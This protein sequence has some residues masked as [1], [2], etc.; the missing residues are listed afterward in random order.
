M[1]LTEGTWTRYGEEGVGM[2]MEGRRGIGR[3]WKNKVKMRVLEESLED[4]RKMEERERGGNGVM[5]VPSDRRNQAE[6]NLKQLQCDSTYTNY[7][8]Q[9]T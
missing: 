1:D 2:D 9:S 7:I 3:K 8:Y 5:R 6:E 4:N